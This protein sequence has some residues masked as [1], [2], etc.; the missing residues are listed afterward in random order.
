[1]DLV[2]KP[3]QVVAAAGNV[4]HLLLH[5]GLADLRPMPRTLVD[6]GERHRVYHS[7]AGPG[8]RRSAASPVLLVPPLAV[9]GDLLRPA[10]RLLAASSTWSRG[11]RPAYVVE[12]ARS[13]SATPTSALE[14]WVDEVL[15]AAVRAAS[16][17][18]GG[19]PV[20]VVGWSLGG[21]FALLAAARDADLPIASL[22]VL[23]APGRRRRRCRCS[24]RCGR[25]SARPT[26]PARWASPPRVVG[27]A[28]AGALGVRARRRPAAG[29]P[30]GR[31]RRRTST[32]PTGSRSSRRSTG[33]RPR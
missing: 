3:D 1:M 8:R 10:P 5:G 20:H 17:H 27:S 13:T 9:P 6:E 28:P 14:P 18:A 25:C 23:G 22:S 4:A 31:R 32:T 30:A 15:P 33:S 16:R 29:D 2:P 11:G 12:S 21:I 19:R 7:R 26:G 24:R